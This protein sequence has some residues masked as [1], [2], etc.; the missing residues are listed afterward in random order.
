M[1][2]ARLA[3]GLSQ[4]DLSFEGCTAAYVSRIEA[5][6]RTP[7]Y[8]ILREFAKRVGVS[9]D[10]LAVGD[11]GV[12]APDPL[13]EAE[14]ALRLGELERAEVIYAGTASEAGDAAAEARADAGLGAVA[15]EHGKVAEAIERL[16]RT[17]SS[18]LLPLDEAEKAAERLGRAYCMQG[19][20]D[21]AFGVLKRFIEDARSRRDRF[22]TAR[23]C[24]LLANAYV[25]AGNYAAAESV[26][27]DALA[28]ATDMIDPMLRANLYWSQ[29][30]LYSSEGN[31]DLAADYAQLAVVTL[32]STEHVLAAARALLLQAQIENDRGNPSEALARLDEAG[33]ELECAGD[34]VEQ[35]TV[36]IERARALAALGDE[37]EAVSLMLGV[38][39]RL[40][41]ARPAAAVIAYASVAGFFR[42]HGDSA[43]ALELY[44]LAI[45]RAPA[46]SR[47]VADALTAMAEIHEEQGRPDEALRLLKSALA[48]R[49]GVTP[50]SSLSR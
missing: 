35:A 5:G 4:R 23:F 32:R 41:E 24:V 46:P 28:T 1:R 39:P 7:S 18:G 16:G 50:G 36:S 17:V 27:S 37:E 9:A 20:F 6:A 44:E 22:A 8:Q 13:V 31:S 49:S 3:A 47:H 25:D 15:L 26:L 42:R 30:R 43:R 45:D 29:C 2:A 11:D 48:A 38:V 14:I 33:P 34:E 19:Q 10:Y 12:A 21:E 40:N